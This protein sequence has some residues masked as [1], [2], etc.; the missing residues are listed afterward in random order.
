MAVSAADLEK[1]FNVENYKRKFK[2]KGVYEVFYQDYYKCIVGFYVM[3][4]VL[5]AN[6]TLIR[7]SLMGRKLFLCNEYSMFVFKFLFD[8]TNLVNQYTFAREMVVL[9]L[10]KEQNF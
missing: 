3:F 6:D 2:S 7:K 5:Y 9:I 4:G 1:G 10:K 8:I